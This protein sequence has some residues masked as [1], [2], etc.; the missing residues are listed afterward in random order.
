M[1]TQNVTLPLPETLFLRFQQM[2]T[3]TR[4]PLTG[5]LLRAVEVGGPPSWEE[6]PARF[7]ADL[8]ALD[9][10]DDDALWRV[11][12]SRPSQAAVARLQEL[13][14]QQAEDR[15]KPEEQSELKQL[16]QDADLLMLRKAHAV[17]LLRW[18]GHA[19]PPAEKL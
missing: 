6:A 8:A 12:R 16:M 4:Q 9:R 7:Q 11:A 5:L 2:A 18:R 14:E 19:I 10:L 1:N 17:T 13:L 15:L 3:A